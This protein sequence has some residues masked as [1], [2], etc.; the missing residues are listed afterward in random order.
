MVAARGNERE[1]EP[2]LPPDA[3]SADDIRR[4]RERSVPHYRVRE[5]ERVEQLQAEKLLQATKQ[6]AEASQR[7][8]RW[9]AWAAIIALAALAVSAWPHITLP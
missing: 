2:P 1:D 4:S 8:T 5:R 9:A 7:S 6:G 3:S